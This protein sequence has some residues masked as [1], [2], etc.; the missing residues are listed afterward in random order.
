MVFSSIVQN[1]HIKQKHLFN[2]LIL[3][4]KVKKEIGHKVSSKKQL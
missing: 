4:Y 2:V 3:C 1:Y